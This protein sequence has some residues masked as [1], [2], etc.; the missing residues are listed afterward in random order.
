MN[1][2]NA[3]IYASSATTAHPRAPGVA[4]AQTTSVPGRCTPGRS[5]CQTPLL[6]FRKMKSLMMSVV[7]LR[8]CDI[9]L[10]DFMFGLQTQ[11][12]EYIQPFSWSCNCGAGLYFEIT[13][14]TSLC[15]TP[16]LASPNGMRHEE[17]GRVW[18]TSGHFI[19]WL[20]IS[21][22]C[23]RMGHYIGIPTSRVPVFKFERSHG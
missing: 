8:S 13:H 4:A 3:F 17:C 23:V 19:Q 20:R 6:K 9:M 14:G 18:S 15:K 10:G 12:F 21:A 22:T 16:L 11:L 7:V 1:S 5:F 2:H